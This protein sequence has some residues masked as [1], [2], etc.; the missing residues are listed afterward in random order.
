[1]HS[2]V[3]MF[4]TISIFKFSVTYWALHLSPHVFPNLFVFIAATSCGND[5]LVVWIAYQVLFQDPA[6]ALSGISAYTNMV[7]VNLVDS[8][9]K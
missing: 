2:M 6:M 8:T 4:V 5:V 3:M 7:A 1:M 9:V